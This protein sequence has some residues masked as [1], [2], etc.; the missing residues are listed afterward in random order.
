MKLEPPVNTNYAATVITLKNLL[1]LDGCDNVVG[2]T[3]FG[4]QGIISRD[5]NIGDIGLVFTAETQ[6][7][8]AFCVENN[9][10]RHDDKNKNLG[11]KGYLEDNRRV[12]AMKFRGH[13]SDCLFMPLESLKYTGIKIEELKEGDIF[14]KIGDQ[15]ICQ[16]YVVKSSESQNRLDKNKDKTFKRVESQFMPEHYDSDNFFRNSDT[17]PPDQ[18]VIVT[19]K[20]HGTSIRVANTVVR[21]KLNLFEKILKKLGTKISESDFDNV[22]GSRKVVKD[23]NNPNQNHFYA[24]DVWTEAGKTLDGLLPEGYIVYGELIG[25]TSEGAVLQKGYTY[26]LPVSTFA[27]YV[28]RVAF[29]NHQGIIADLAW[30]QVKEFCDIR[31][32][33]YVPELYRGKMKDFVV[34][35]YLNRR[36]WDE[37]YKNCLPLPEDLKLVD[38]GVCIRVDRLAPYILKAKSSVFL[39]HETK[40]LDQGVEDL[41]TQESIV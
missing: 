7:S 3:L 31:G 30:N 17:I 33:K 25:Y 40:M 32:M 18:E 8:D 10:Y 16:K 26:G 39:E 11:V 23:I 38:E 41:E 29:I 15:I 36:F 34:E 19:Q 6:L 27:L 12:K 9:L 2:T 20:L 22:Y 5:H 28:Y 21:R 1:P 37:G 13:R 35:N 24:S 4:F 14:D